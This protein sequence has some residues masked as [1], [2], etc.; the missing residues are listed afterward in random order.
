MTIR[1]LEDLG[2]VRGNRV[3]VRVD[4]N[5][6]LEG[7]EIQDD[8]RIRA[9]LP[10]LHDLLDAGAALVLASHLGR[11]KGRVR[12]DLRMAP[13]ADRLAELLGRDVA[14]VSDVAGEEAQAVCS[15]VEPGDV[16]MLENLRFD[17][18]E[19][20]NNAAF[21]TNLSQL[22]DVYV[23]DAFGAAHR[24]MRPSWVRRSSCR[25]RRGDCSRVK[26]RSSAACSTSRDV[27]SSGSWVVSKSA[28]SSASSRRC[29]NGATVC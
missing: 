4:Y 3:F 16:V 26:S 12:E 22:G 24:D 5:V 7:R 6:P 1:A 10:T 21:A 14:A 19:E 13:V 27:H 17:P 29:C 28:T 20:T 15:H 8:L 23:D 9:S 25:R 2:E 11:P 18:G